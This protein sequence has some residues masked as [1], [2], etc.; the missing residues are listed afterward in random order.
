M[1]TEEAG[2]VKLEGM[3]RYF[4]TARKLRADAKGGDW[5]LTLADGSQVRATDD[6]IIRHPA[7]TQQQGQLFKHGG[8]AHE[9]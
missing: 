9:N 3:R 1:K 7:G 4:L 5:L 8:N 2:L 6:Q